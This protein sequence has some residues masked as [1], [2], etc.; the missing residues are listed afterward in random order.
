MCMYLSCMRSV[1][2]TG[3]GLQKG[4]SDSHAVGVPVRKKYDV[5]WFA[6]C[7]LAGVRLLPAPK[8]SF[9]T[10]E[11]DMETILDGTDAASI[12]QAT[13]LYVARRSTPATL[14]CITTGEACGLQEVVNRSRCSVGE[15]RMV[16]ML[17]DV[18][19]YQQS[20]FLMSRGEHRL[21]FSTGLLIRAWEGV[22]EARYYFPYVCTVLVRSE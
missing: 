21:N 5:V 13:L 12:E 15:K 10:P 17:A 16:N 20:A 9:V 3:F 18:A 6:A 22:D 7:D 8:L 11:A 4:L 19:K 1:M 2:R 14:L